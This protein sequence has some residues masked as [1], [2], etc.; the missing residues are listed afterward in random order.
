[1][2]VWFA[3]LP[4]RHN[5]QDSAAEYRVAEPSAHGWHALLPLSPW[6]VPGWQSSQALCE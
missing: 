6:Y 5:W 4:E 3:N 2:R 1:M